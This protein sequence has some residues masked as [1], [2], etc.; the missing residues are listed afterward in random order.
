MVEATPDRPVVAAP[1]APHLKV[2]S[3]FF[4]G[5]ASA[6]LPIAA[7][8]LLDLC[9]LHEG[10]AVPVP[11]LVLGYLATVTGCVL[12]NLPARHTGGVAFESTPFSRRAPRA[13]RL[14]RATLCAKEPR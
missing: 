1:L 14:T 11:Y 13:A 5:S 10:V 8:P 2:H 7:W 4:G 9:M 3:T 6:H 12:Y